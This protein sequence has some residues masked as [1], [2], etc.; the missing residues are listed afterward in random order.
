MGGQLETSC[1][2]LKST[3]TLEQCRNETSSWHRGSWRAKNYNGYFY[4]NLAGLR[5]VQTAGNTLFLGVS[6]AVFLKEIA[7]LIGELRKAD[8]PPQC[9]CISNLCK[10]RTKEK[11]EEGR[12]CVLS[13][14]WDIHL[15]LSCAWAFRLTLTAPL[16]FLVVQIADNR[17]WDFSAFIMTWANVYDKSP[18]LYILL[19]LFLWTNVFPDNME[20]LC[21]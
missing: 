8:G 3:S 2:K 6:M 13:L 17:S 11:A 18:H 5:D 21:P 14:S 10:A 4:V 1:L 15:P 12:V 20:L 9:E 16:A 19:V 7:L